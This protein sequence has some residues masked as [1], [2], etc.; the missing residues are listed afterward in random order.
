MTF[1]LTNREGFTIKKKNFG[2]KEG[3]TSLYLR[4]NMGMSIM[5]F[6]GLKCDTNG[7][8]DNGKSRFIGVDL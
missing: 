3:K 1:D 6:F 8:V 4:Y 7:A 5:V 2:A